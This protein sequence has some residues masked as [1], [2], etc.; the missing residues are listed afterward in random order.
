MLPASFSRRL[1]LVVLS[2]LELL[3]SNLDLAPL[4]IL[5]PRLCFMLVRPPCSNCLSCTH[6]APFPISVLL[7]LF[8]ACS[9]HSLPPPFASVLSVLSV[10]CFPAW[11]PFFL[12]V[13]LSLS[14]PVLFHSLTILQPLC[15][16]CLLF[17]C[18]CG[19]ELRWVLQRTAGK[20]KK[21][22]SPSYISFSCSVFP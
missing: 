22:L 3:L 6:R 15:F 5:R 11:P 12:T 19:L 10:S 16:A 8:L 17:L 1:H 9:A 4:H 21:G 13:S 20:K 7:F 2:I 18:R 14:R